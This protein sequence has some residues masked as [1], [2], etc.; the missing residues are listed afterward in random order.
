VSPKNGPSVVCEIAV[1][2]DA[3]REAQEFL[4]IDGASVYALAWSST[5]ELYCSA[6]RGGTERWQIY[7]RTPK[8]TVEKVAGSES[9]SAQ[10]HLSHNSVSPNGRIVA[11]SSNDR[12]AEDVDIVLI[13]TATHERRTVVGSPGWHVVGGWS[14][15]G[16]WLSVMR[17]WQNTDQDVLALDP[18]T[19]E[20]L[21]LTL[22]QGEMQNVPCGWLAN[23]RLL[24]ITDHD[25]HYLHLDSIDVG[26]GTRSRWMA[27]DW[28][29]ELATVSPDGQTVFGSLN[30]DGY[31]RIFWRLG[32]GPFFS[33]AVNGTCDDAVLSQD[34]KR[35]AYTRSPI[36]G[37][38]EIRVVDLY[39][40]DDWLLLRG[41]P[42]SDEGTARPVTLRV[43]GP[44]GL[45]PCFVYRP[46]VDGRMPALLYIHGGPEGQSRPKLEYQL[47]IELNRRGVAIVV[48]N[49][50]GST[51]YGGAWQRRIHRDWGGIDLEDLRAVADWMKDHP[52]FD[53]RR[54]G[55]FGTS[56]GGFATMMCVTRLPEYWCCAAEYV[57]PVNLVTWL[58]NSAPNWRRWNRLWVGDLDM[59]REKLLARSPITYLDNLQ[60]PLLIVQGANDPRV[61]MEE[62]EQVVSRLRELGRDV[63]YMC[64]DGEGHG[65][66]MG[67]N[68]QIAHDRTLAFF[69]DHL[70]GE[71]AGHLANETTQGW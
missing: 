39:S 14:P 3:I 48:P 34:G 57:G 10:H 27:T 31:S 68:Q 36:T 22:H 37:P 64:F 42:I 30:E 70:I 9:D 28:D 11:I 38:T 66:K 23:G 21:E 69:L 61:P 6:D 33:R 12:V 40:G 13:D 7:A 63:S 25:S 32:E 16:R 20:A 35:A 53:P 2:K 67:N 50:H 46:Q 5:G 45:I 54:L 60:C 65:L 15:D 29:I 24:V 49:I 4:S 18:K 52:N 56:Y 51:G 26:T 41:E 59:D 17:V 55:V 58:E 44:E 43:A 19:G 62:S 47:L 8:G 1:E 71:N